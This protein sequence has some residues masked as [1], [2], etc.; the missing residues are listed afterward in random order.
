MGEM[1]NTNIGEVGEGML[2]KE[3][4][5]YWGDVALYEEEQKRALFLLGYLVGEIGNAQSA[6]GHKKKPILDKINFQGMG[7]DK[8]RRLANDV[9]EKLRQ[10]DRLQYNEN[11]YSVLK[12]LMDNNMGKWYL[13]NQENVFYVLSG[14]AFSNYLVRKRSKDK[15]FEE[16]KKVSEYIEKA[17]EEGKRT[18][19]M[20]KI[21]EEAKELAENYKYSEAR[22]LLK[23]IEIPNKDKEVE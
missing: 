1:S 12:S 21:L 11:I 6:T 8:L 2:P 4:L 15:C 7:A 3:I 19:E 23:K 14:Y 10:Y 22:K 20:E 5:D 17:K 16:L 18:E 9:L 13:S